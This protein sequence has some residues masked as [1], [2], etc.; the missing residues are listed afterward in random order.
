M[1]DTSGLAKYYQPEIGSSKVRHIIDNSSNRI[2]ISDLSIVE[3][4][5]TLAKKVR[6]GE[7]T[8]STFHIARHRF[9]ADVVAGKFN[10]VELKHQHGQSA[11]KLLVKHA[12]KRGLRTLD[13]LQLTIA[14]E[15]RSQK[16]V[17]TFVC[18]DEKL[19]K[20]AKLEKIVFLN[21]ELP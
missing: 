7:I 2:F 4:V 9:F 20:V 8:A 10:I 19:S 6:I 5:S 1:F 15:L 16:N 13:S 17:D 12:T 21:P 11:I 14:L 3:L 18:A